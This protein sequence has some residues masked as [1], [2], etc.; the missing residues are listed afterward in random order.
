MHDWDG[1]EELINLPDHAFQRKVDKRVLDAAR[2]HGDVLKVALVCPPT[3]YGEY[4]R[5][6]TII[7]SSLLT[8]SIARGGCPCSQSGRQVYELANVTLRLQKCPII[9]AGQA[10][11]SNVYIQDLSKLYA[12][13][14]D[15]AVAGRADHGLWGPKAYYLTDNAERQWGDLAKSTADAAAKQRFIAEAKAEPIDL[16]SAK[17]YAGF[18][19]LSWGMNSRGRALRA[20]KI[21]GWNPS[22]PSLLEELPQVVQSEW[23][24][25][26]CRSEKFEAAKA[27]SEGGL[28]MLRSF[29]RSL[30]KSFS[31]ETGNGLFR[32]GKNRPKS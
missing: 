3:I 30:R 18:E 29:P 19:P 6:A 31:M 4:P 12:L 25:L 28:S 17:L 15:A 5:E 2:K 9:G 13:L 10:I 23:Q 24:R 22:C 26:D 20:R 16:Q 1:V 7:L 32:S 8:I 27:C 21:L 11:W 14:V